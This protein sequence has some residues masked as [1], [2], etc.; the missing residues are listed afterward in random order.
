MLS[1]SP[2]LFVDHMLV[3]PRLQAEIVAR[4]QASL[5]PDDPASVATDLGLLR[6]L[7]ESEMRVWQ[8]H[9]ADAV[10]LDDVGQIVLI[11][12]L[13]NP[14]RGKLALPGGLLDVTEAGVE[15]SLHAALREAAEETGIPPDH[16]RTATV[17]KLGHRRFQ[18]P[19]DIRQAWNNLPGTPIR[20]GELF[21]VS[22]LGF[23]VRVRGDLR[24]IALKPG[25]DAAAVKILPACDVSPESLT[26][27]D[28]LDLIK[29]ALVI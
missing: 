21:T 16:L 9:A 12:R 17:T 4:C 23:R 8:V 29:A 22:T 19:F 27:Q 14:G 25:D 20:Q 18:R 1:A 26:V 24:A 11:T 6:L 10:L 15:S 2:A 5:T 3:D 28:H 7:G 13:H